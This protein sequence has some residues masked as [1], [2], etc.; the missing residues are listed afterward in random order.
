MTGRRLSA[1]AKGKGLGTEPYQAPRKARVRVQEPDNTYLIQ[2][3]S[4]TI[5]GR[6]TNPSVQ[7]VWSLLP[8][9]TK[10]WSTGSRPIGS[11]LGQG[12]F[13]FQFDNEADLLEVLDKRPYH[14]AKWMIIIQRWEPTTTQDFPSLIP[15]WIKF[16]G[17]PLHLWTED[18]IRSI[19]SVIEYPNGDEVTANL[20]YEKL[21]KHC[22][23]CFKLDHELRD[24]FKA[25]AE[26]RE[27]QTVASEKPRERFQY[28]SSPGRN[29]HSYQQRTSNANPAQSRNADHRNWYLNN[30]EHK[31]DYRTNQYRRRYQPYSQ[32][33]YDSHD[34]PGNHNARNTIYREVNRSSQPPT[35]FPP[36][37]PP[38]SARDRTIY[39]S[40]ERAYSAREGSRTSI[41]EDHSDLPLEALNEAWEELIDVMTQYMSCADPSESAVHR[42]R[43]RQAEQN[44]QLEETVTQMARSSLANNPTRSLRDNHLKSPERTPTLL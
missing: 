16:Q 42:E 3:H 35:N 37:P 18:T 21:E 40:S 36:P 14:Y 30:R 32:Y 10:K 19:G 23:C 31:Q 5:V 26:K 2:K 29:S 27:A 28:A 33:R 11:D 15:F 44:G 6:V 34:A 38:L 20:V 39:R 7:K 22:Y 25:K 12:M 24:C 43:L 8:F 17:I 9:F 1:N 4:L 41:P 13:Q